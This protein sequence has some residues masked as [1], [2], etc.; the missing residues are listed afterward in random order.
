MRWLCAVALAGCNQ[1]YGL[2][3]TEPI[4]DDRD[5]DGLLDV[6]DNCPDIANPL[7]EN[8]D[9]DEL[10]DICDPCPPG[11]NHNE[12]SDTLLDGCDNC[13]DAAN[14]DQAN[15]DGD[16]LGDACD[17]D[18]RAQRRVRFDGFDLLTLHWIP[19]NI[20]WVSEADA[21]HPL[22]PSDPLDAGLWDRRDEAAGTSYFIAV[23]FD[24]DEI[25]GVRTGMWTRQRTA[26]TEHQCYIQRTAGAWTLTVATSASGATQSTPV[27]I[28]H[29]LLL[30]LR[31]DGTLIH[32]ET[33]T[34]HVMIDVVDP[35]TYPG[36]YT[37]GVSRYLSADIV[38]SS[39]D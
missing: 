16:E 22:G 32:C 6:I 7:Q 36:L 20:D 39:A 38:T 5:G 12:D 3:P 4:T 26:G 25:D 14:E 2:D 24:V 29:P 15:A 17:P 9:D 1:V 34:A 8:L 31:R 33:P 13:P 27:A 10:G 11:S 30:R 37:T 19:G 35:V 18:A 28:T 21:I 23:M